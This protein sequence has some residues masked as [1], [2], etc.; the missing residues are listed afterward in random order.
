MAPSRAG[1]RASSARS[2]TSS[3]P[4]AQRRRVAAPSPQP[5]PAPPADSVAPHRAVTVASTTLARPAPHRHRAVAADFACSSSR[6]RGEGN[7]WSPAAPARTRNAARELCAACCRGKQGLT[8]QSSI[9]VH[10]RCHAWKGGRIRRYRFVRGR[11]INL[12]S[13]LRA[14]T[15]MHWREIGRARFSSFKICDQPLVES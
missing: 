11:A 15:T 5:S 14:G 13:R 2:C 12:C 7:R 3:P 9:P 6:P 4:R 10:R 1:R 8:A